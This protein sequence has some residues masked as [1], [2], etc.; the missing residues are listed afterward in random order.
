MF[1]V[2]WTPIVV[3]SIGAAATVASVIIPLMVSIHRTARKALNQNSLEH[4][5]TKQMLGHLVEGQQQ[6]GH[7]ATRI[8]E[9][10]D[11]HITWHAHRHEEDK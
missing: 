1:G 10:V 6:L 7:L 11:G 8:E 5:E 4:G 9:K 2:E 3:A